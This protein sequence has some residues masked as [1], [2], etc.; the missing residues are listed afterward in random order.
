MHLGG[1]KY[2]HK[3]RNLKGVLERGED[4][5]IWDI[6]VEGG[7]LWTIEYTQGRKGKEMEGYLRS[8]RINQTKGHMKILQG[9][10]LFYNLIE[11][12]L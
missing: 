10:L 1:S 6:N 2:G 8:R 5:R 3:T 4:N 11:N 9:N 12:Y 7:L